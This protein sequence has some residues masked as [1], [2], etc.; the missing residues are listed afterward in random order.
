MSSESA[1]EPQNRRLKIGID[2]HAIGERATGNER[3]I[4]GVLGQ[5]REMCDHDFVLFFT[6]PEASEAWAQQGWETRLVPS[7]PVFRVGWS[8][9]K[10]T[11]EEALDVLLVQYVASRRVR[12]PVVAVVHDV[13]FMEHPEWFSGSE[14]M[15]MKRAIPGT[16]AMATTV[17]TV[18]SFSRYEIIRTCGIPPEKIRI[19][20]DGVDQEPRATSV[21]SS[22]DS[23]YF[24]YLGNLEPRKNVATLLSAFADFRA[25]HRDHRLLLAGHRKRGGT[26]IDREGVEYLGYVTEEQLPELVAN[27]VALC[28]PSLYEGFGLPPLEAMSL[29]TPVIA[30]DIPVMR[31]IY[32]DAALLVPAT[33]RSAWSEAL[34]RVSSDTGLRSEL[35]AAG[36]DRATNFT[37]RA[38]ARIVLGALEDAVP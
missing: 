17:V 3:F 38:S 1:S 5:L 32:S 23:P 15:W 9:P 4:T 18:S 35:S 36:R 26:T 19:A 24:L 28:Y 27:A 12:C 11:R 25:T 14:R 16:M 2:A 21:G 6:S 37:W 20:Y 29:G 10:L 13:S 34:T 7:N 31:E 30:S 22:A 8:I 33:D